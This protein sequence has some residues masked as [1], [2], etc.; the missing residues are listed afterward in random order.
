MTTNGTRLSEPLI[1]QLRLADVRVKVSLH[2]PKELHDRMLGIPCFDLVDR[3][4]GRLLSAEIS[5]AIQTVVTRL[6][7]DVLD[8]VVE[9]CV[10]HRIRKLR[11]VPFVPR[12]RGMLTADAYQL[13]PA[14]RDRIAEAIDEARREQGHRLD[15]EM[16]DFW[17]Q[18]YFVMETDGE[19]Q[20]QRETDSSDS[21]V[22]ND[23]HTLITLTS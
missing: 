11:F 2:G 8:W 6:Q 10:A 4:V 3:N 17:T 15:I 20:I 21:T 23:G 13:D 12:G 9:Y 18:E 5:L 19:L 16:L 1:E 22:L 7:P 14:Q